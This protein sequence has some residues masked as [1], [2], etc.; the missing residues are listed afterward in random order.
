MKVTPDTNV[1][2]SGT[3]WT[4]NSFRILELIDKKQLISVLSKEIIKE[5]NKVI[6]SN[7]IIEKI[8]NKKLILLKVVQKVITN[9]DI[10]EPKI[11]LDVVK[12]DKDDNKIL[13][14]AKEG[15]VD[16]II[17]QDEHLL[18]LKKYENILIVKPGYF[19]KMIGF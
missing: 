13:E 14:C 15:N 10:V 2:I 3:F 12:E 5:Y 8:E 1:L 7:E 19:L 9:S 18:K 17:T 6:N 16:Y 11:K 4:G